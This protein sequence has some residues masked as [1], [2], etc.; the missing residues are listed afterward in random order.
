MKPKTCFWRGEIRGQGQIF[1]V[2]VLAGSG[3]SAIWIMGRKAGA[4]YWEP[5]AGWN[6]S[7]PDT[8]NCIPQSSPPKR[9]PTVETNTQRTLVLGQVV[10]R[11]FTD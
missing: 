3:L 8:L 11:Q 7:Q 1:G 5:G 2:T 4:E 6:G 9:D 10:L